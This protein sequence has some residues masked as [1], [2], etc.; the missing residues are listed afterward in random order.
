LKWKGPEIK[1]PT[2]LN[3]KPAE[4]AA[5]ALKN[6]TERQRYIAQMQLNTQKADQG[7]NKFVNKVEKTSPTITI[8]VATKYLG[9]PLGNQILKGTFGKIAQGGMHESL[10]RDTIIL[11]H[12]GERVDIDKP[13]KMVS[14]GGGRPQHI[15]ISFEPAEF[16][17]FLRVSINE[18]QGYQK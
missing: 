10:S 9:S 12:K 15:R 11:A 17:Q 14:M 2:G 18:D 1:I 8:K 16:K 7:L 13:E 5:G 4:I 6:K 3:T